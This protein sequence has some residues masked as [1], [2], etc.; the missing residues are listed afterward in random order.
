L[1]SK[2]GEYTVRGFVAETGFYTSAEAFDDFV[3]GN[4]QV[5]FADYV[6]VKWDNTLMLNMKKFKEE[7]IDVLSCRWYKNGELLGEGLTW[8]Q[9][10]SESDLLETADYSFELTTFDHG[11]VLSYRYTYVRTQNSV[12]VYPNPVVSG[13]ELTL[14]G[15]EASD[16]YVRIYNATGQIVQEFRPEGN[17]TTIT[18]H[19][20]EGVYFI[21]G[22]GWKTIKLVVKSKN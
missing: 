9:G 6:V 15:C 8:S 4:L 16:G 14:E 3:I 20:P 11:D 12:K 1:P 7:G 22:T 18:L 13:Q 2:P 5:A 10:P 21:I 19:Q 17:V